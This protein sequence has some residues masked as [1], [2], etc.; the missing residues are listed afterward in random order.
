MLRS[1]SDVRLK[2]INR[3]YG[4]LY[5]IWMMNIDDKNVRILKIRR[6]SH[7]KIHMIQIYISTIY[8]GTKIKVSLELFSDFM[9]LGWRGGL[10]LVLKSLEKFYWN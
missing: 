9:K 6:K 3:K 1:L 8:V 4:K 5:T 2:I 7:L 10:V